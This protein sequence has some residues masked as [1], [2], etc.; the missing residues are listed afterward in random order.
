VGRVEVLDE[1][2]T[3]AD[4]ERHCANA[5]QGLFDAL[6]KRLASISPAAPEHLRA[7]EVLLDY[8]RRRIRIHTEPDGNLVVSA[9]NV[10]TRRIL[11]L[12]LFPTTAGV[13]VSGWRLL[14]EFAT[15]G[16]RDEGPGRARLAADAPEL[17]HRWLDDV[18]A[19]EN[20]VGPQPRAAETET[21]RSLSDWLTDNLS[22][23][24]PD[25]EDPYVIR[26]LSPSDFER[27]GLNY[28]VEVDAPML[29]T[30]DAIFL[31][32]DFWLLQPLLGR[33][34]EPD[35]RDASWVLLALYAKINELKLSVTNIHEMHFQSTVLDWLD[36]K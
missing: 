24:R 10:T 30:A 27:T 33:E 1:R 13:S 9:Y 16:G 26:I 31:R 7:L 4:L 19:P 2:F 29:V 21:F 20:V 36:L 17:L 35:R 14:R 22:T 12:P 15:F 11:E 18:L 25:E 8:A 3:P 5:A 32:S 28:S 6:I 34:A 23:L